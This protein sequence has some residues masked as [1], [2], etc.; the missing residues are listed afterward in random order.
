MLQLNTKQPEHSTIQ[1]DSNKIIEHSDMVM[2]KASTTVC[3]RHMVWLPDIPR[4][5]MCQTVL[6]KQLE[7]DKSFTEKA[8]L[9]YMK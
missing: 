3:Y 1:E 6:F 8:K 4:E 5:Y 2:F 9:Q 7:T